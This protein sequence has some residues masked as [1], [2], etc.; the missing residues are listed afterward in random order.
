MKLA[1][2]S[3]FIM[4]S[5]MTFSAEIVHGQ[6]WKIKPESVALQTL[7]ATIKSVLVEKVQRSGDSTWR[8]LGVS[9]RTKGIIN[10]DTYIDIDID[11]V[12]KSFKGYTTSLIASSKVRSID[13]CR[14]QLEDLM[15]DINSGR[16]I[17][18]M[19]K[20]INC[21]INFSAR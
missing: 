1:I 18:E 13:Y 4:T 5:T 17:L 6:F 14:I 19:T 10:R 12:T 2:F 16:N 3:I 7:G 11:S 8:F 21:N 9:C 15:L 20:D